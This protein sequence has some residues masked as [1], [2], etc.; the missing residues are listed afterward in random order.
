[1]TSRNL[2]QLEYEVNRELSRWTDQL[3]VSVD[4]NL[5][6]R[7]KSAAFREMNERW[8]ANQATPE[9]TPST[10]DRVR[11]TVHQEIHNRRRRSGF[12]RW[13]L[14]VSAAAAA[15]AVSVTATL[16][17]TTTPGRQ[18]KTSAPSTPTDRVALFVESA[19]DVLGEDP[20]LLAIEMALENIENSVSLHTL[21]A[22]VEE[23][24]LDELGNDIDSLFKDIKTLPREENQSTSYRSDH[25]G[26]YLG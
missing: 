7:A 8:L 26:G 9:P 22:D 16:F 11:S 15:I 2:K 13:S 14:F 20:Q 3:D 23:Q 21:N 19:E 5:V 10:I 25:P 12:R 6:D 1:M 4:Q 24:I 18:Q 17:K